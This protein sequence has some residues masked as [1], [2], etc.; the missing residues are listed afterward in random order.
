MGILM[1]KPDDSVLVHLSR[2]L[3]H[4]RSMQNDKGF[5]WETTWTLPK[6]V[7]GKVDEDKLYRIWYK[8]HDAADPCDTSTH[9][10]VYYMEEVEDD[11]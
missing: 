4:G 8:Y 2:T 3:L 10:T 1:K 11:G 7:R 9:Y 5:L 6:E